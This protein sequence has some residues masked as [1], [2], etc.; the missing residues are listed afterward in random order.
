M[1]QSRD[2]AGGGACHHPEV[3]DDGAC[4]LCGGCAHDVVLNGAC[5]ACGATDVALTNKDLGGA[6]GDV[7]PAGRLS[8]PRR[9]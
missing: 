1:G 6:A 9:R 2:Q 5:V 3:G 4:V 8:G 7:V